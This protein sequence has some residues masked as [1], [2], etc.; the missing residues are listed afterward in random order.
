MIASRTSVILLLCASIFNVMNVVLWVKQRREKTSLSAPRR[1]Y[2]HKGHD[3]PE[4]LPLP[5]DIETMLVPVEE[6]V[7]YSPLGTASDVEWLALAEPSFGYVRLGP[8]DR[9]FV[10][11]MFHELHCL[12]MLNLAFSPNTTAFAH[13]T[14]CLNYLRQE[15][16]CLPDLALEPGDFEKRD[17]DM[18]RSHGLHEC[19]DWSVVQDTASRN[20]ESWSA[21]T[22]Y[23]ARS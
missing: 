3:Y 17:L 19:R 13:V 14:H 1:T 9:V 21:K 11:T 8:D 22:G 5:H 10:V 16:L 15:A 7:H 2:S 18:E 12:R 23:S 4:L 20:F 6:S